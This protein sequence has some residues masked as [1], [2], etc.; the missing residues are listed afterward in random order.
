[1]IYLDSAA[2]TLQKP[3]SVSEAVARAVRTLTSPG[4]GG[5]QR[6]MDAANTVFTC[7][8]EAARLFNVPNPEQVVFTFNATHGLNIAI[9]S[10]VSQGTRVVISGYEHN[11]VTRTLAS[12]PGIDL[13]VARSNLFDRVRTSEAFRRELE[14]GADVVICTHVSNVFGFILP[15]EEIAA[16]CQENKTKLIVDASQSAGSIPVD[17]KRLSADFLAVP[18]HKGLYGPQGTGLLLCKNQAEPLI[19]GGTGSDS[20]LQNMPD[21]LP[22]RLEAGTYNVPG[23]AGL[24]E[25]LRYLRRRGIENIQRHE[26]NMIVRAKKKLSQLERVTLF[27][28]EDDGVQSGVLSLQ[29]EGMDCEY[30]AQLLGERGI[31]VRAGLHCAPE[32]HRSAG[33]LDTGTVRLSVSDFNTE[34]EIDAFVSKMKSI[35]KENHHKPGLR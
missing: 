35:I 4:R 28:G 15:I 26:R 19:F 11:A 32:A 10:L 17:F 33:T 13:S 14:S 16:L 24:L 7:R 1:M 25:G 30:L 31:A 27:F 2:T 34:T 9:R 8:E 22:E 12:I 5:Y 21:Y 3:I 23:I 29:V 20:A 6:S 18:G